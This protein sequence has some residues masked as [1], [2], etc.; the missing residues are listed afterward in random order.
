MNE[1][2][3]HKKKLHYDENIEKIIMESIDQIEE[4][5]VKREFPFDDLKIIDFYYDFLEKQ[6]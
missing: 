4:L 5:M 3:S 1:Y 6:I 2:R